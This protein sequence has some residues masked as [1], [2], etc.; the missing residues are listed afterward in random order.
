[1]AAPFIQPDDI[2]LT[3]QEVGRDLLLTISGGVRHIGAVSTAYPEEDKV[4]VQTSAVP[5]HKEHTISE[6]IALSVARALGRTVTVVMGIHY[7]DLSREGIQEVVDI[8]QRK[9]DEFLCQQS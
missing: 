2:E 1:M 4:G 9:V 5:H 6:G 7:D 8:V 3:A